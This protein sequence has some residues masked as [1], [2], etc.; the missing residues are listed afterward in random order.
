MKTS[1]KLMAA[2]A[3]GGLGVA[4]VQTGC[5]GTSTSRS[6]GQYVDDAAIT[7]KVKTALI[8]DEIVKARQVEVE[9]YKGNVQLSGFVE[10]PAQKQRAVQVA[11]S[12]DGVVNVTDNISIRSAAE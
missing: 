1:M 9:T 5:A 12:I 11:R 8:D 4:L 2:L 10:T 6:T 7:T 3:L